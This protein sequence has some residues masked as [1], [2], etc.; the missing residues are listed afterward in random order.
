MTISLEKYTK[1]YLEELCKDSF[2]LAEVLR[3][4][5]R[6]PTGG[7]YDI[8]K[9]KIKEFEIE[10]SH[11]TGK[12]WNKGKTKETD[13]RIPSNSTYT[14]EEIFCKNSMVSPNCLKK[15]IKKYNV[16]PYI[17]AKCGC[18]GEWQD[19]IISLEI[20]HEDGDNHNNSVV[21]LQ[22]LCPNCHAL[23]KNY[24]GKNQKRKLTKNST[25]Q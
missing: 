14:Y 25:S 16:I 22:Y 15:N 5:G 1:E 7:N 3:K 23:T 12:L 2:S 4:S 21:N 10:I 20:H 18:T 6:R 8:L 19:G 17:C 13:N 24:R 9:Q 11:F